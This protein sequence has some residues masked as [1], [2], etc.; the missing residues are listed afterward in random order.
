MAPYILYCLGIIVVH[1]ASEYSC[2]KYTSDEKF[3]NL[4]V[5][6]NYVY[7]GGEKNIIHL[8]STLDVIETRTITNYPVNWL[9]TV[10][11]NKNL[12]ACNYKK[13]NSKYGLICLN[14]DVGPKMIS[15]TSR[16]GLN[17]KS[18]SAKYITAT[19]SE[20]KVLIIATSSCLRRLNEDKCRAISGSLFMDQF[21]FEYPKANDAMMY[22]VLYVNDR[23]DSE[24]ISFKS[25]LQKDNFIYFLFNFNETRSKLGKQC[26]SRKNQSKM[27][28]YED[29]PIICTYNTKVFTEA[30]DAVFWKDYLFVAFA[31]D[32]SSVICR[33]IVTDIKIKFQESRQERLK[34]PYSDLINTY[35]KNQQFETANWCYNKST[36][37]CNR[38]N[39]NPANNTCKEVKEDFCNSQLFGSIEGSKPI[40][41]ERI[42]YSE[43]SSVNGAIV[44]LGVLPFFNH[45]VI[46]AGTKTGKIGKIF[47]TGT[48]QKVLGKFRIVQK[49]S[50]VLDIKVQNEDVYVMTENMVI[51]SNIKHVKVIIFQVK[52]TC[53]RFLGRVLEQDFLGYP[54]NPDPKNIGPN[55][56]FQDFSGLVNLK[57]PRIVL[58]SPRVLGLFRTSKPE[59]SQVCPEKSQGCKKVAEKTLSC[60]KKGTNC[61]DCRKMTDPACGWDLN[62]QSCKRNEDNTTWWLP[63]L[64]GECLKLKV[65]DHFISGSEDIINATLSFEPA[66]KNLYN[67]YC[68]YGNA[69]VSASPVSD[70][71]E[72]Y[73]MLKV[74]NETFQLN[75]T[76]RG[77]LFAST[78]VKLMKCSSINSCSRCL[79]SR[80]CFWCLQGSSCVAKSNPCPNNFNITD[81]SSCP[82]I[83]NNRQKLFIHE[84]KSSEVEDLE[85]E[86]ANITVYDIQS[87]ELK[88]TVGNELYAAE[89]TKNDKKHVV[90]KDVKVPNKK[91]DMNLY[92]QYNGSKLDNS[93]ELVVYNCQKFKATCGNCMYR[94]SQGYKCKWCANSSGKKNQCLFN[95][96]NGGCNS[97]PCA[98][99]K[100]VFSVYPN[101]GPEN[102]GTTITISGI[103]I[104][105]PGDPT[106][107]TVNGVGCSEAKV[108]E[109]SVVECKT[110]NGSLSI[111]KDI[112][113]TISNILV[114]AASQFSYKKEL[115][116]YR[117]HPNKSIKAGGKKIHILG[118]NI[119]FEKSVYNITFCNSG[120]TICIPCSFFK[121][122]NHNT[123]QCRMSHSD[124][125]TLQLT[126]LK[127]LIDSNTEL[128]YNG[129][130]QFV[131]NP[132]VA[133]RNED[134][135]KVLKSGGSKIT[136][137]GNGF[138]NVG[139]VTMDNVVRYNSNL[140]QNYYHTAI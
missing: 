116:L 64:G 85:V 9:L 45:A 109:S 63:S 52:Y 134:E 27:N 7:I 103:G 122:L 20:E 94:K 83:Q 50:P 13:D 23:H 25:V 49:F 8:N 92:L 38:V 48:D 84:Q 140:I 69:N 36:G 65:A 118:K 86:V 88:C 120:N 133:D 59:I 136:L 12:I 17:T 35:F 22:S 99:I 138:N 19:F 74:T 106:T 97:T 58:K 131:P 90:C 31:D 81:A 112:K 26:T 125:D 72:F 37:E 1:L 30:Q 119:G 6:S 123:V 10:H 14:F 121:T 135:A 73:C 104:G 11:N 76:Q 34:C 46:Y 115:V 44:K 117:F 139:E 61:E 114:T 124:S 56:T 110:G 3:R 42:I 96:D 93:A 18:S 29:T 129:S 55:G 21:S 5:A 70:N 54:G 78:T 57:Y 75:V 71:G 66:V 68:Q 126:Q 40:T 47:V 82:R 107:V 89:V 105:Y 67:L 111:T 113:V 60:S 98:P 127:V 132:K 102:G 2:D 24:L 51:T 80:R 32:V 53:I 15:R 77:I 33:Y 43:D 39:I 100:G 95:R 137:K 4:A 91:D 108:T 101:S 28:S 62:Q 87:N 41:E 16:I 128:L 79:D 130:F